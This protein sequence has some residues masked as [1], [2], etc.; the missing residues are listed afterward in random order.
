MIGK[1]YKNVKA[2]WNYE[3]YMFVKRIPNLHADAF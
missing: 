2:S 1:V 3:V